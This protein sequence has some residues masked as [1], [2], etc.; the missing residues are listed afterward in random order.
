MSKFEEI[1]SGWKNYVF[2]NEAVEEMAKKRL[3]ICIDNQSQ[4]ENCM[5]DRNFCTKCGCFIPAKVR[6]EKSRCPKGKW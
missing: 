4:N 5:S 3:L 2:K 1:V 6:S